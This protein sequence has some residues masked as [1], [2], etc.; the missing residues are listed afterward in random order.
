LDAAAFGNLFLSQIEFLAGRP[1]V[2]TKIAHAANRL[3]SR[4]RAP[5]KTL[6]FAGN[7]LSTPSLAIYDFERR[8]GGQS[9]SLRDPSRPPD[10]LFVCALGA[11]HG[12]VAR[13]RDL[14][15]FRDLHRHLTPSPESAQRGSPG[16]RGEC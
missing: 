11:L 8:K 14:R 7:L 6:H 3:R 15:R 12:H 2:R 4:S 1:Q 9:R 16:G 5:C 10:S 13:R